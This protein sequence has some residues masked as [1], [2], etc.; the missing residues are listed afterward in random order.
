MYFRLKLSAMK[1]IYVPAIIVLACAGLIV[2]LLLEY[3]YTDHPGKLLYAPYTLAFLSLLSTLTIVNIY[4]LGRVAVKNLRYSGKVYISQEWFTKMK[5]N[6]DEAIIFTD[7]MGSVTSMN[8]K[9]EQLTGWTLAESLGTPMDAIFN[10]IND[11]TELPV[12]SPVTVVLKENR[13]APLAYHT[14]VVKKDNSKRYIFDSAIPIHDTHAEIIGSVLIFHDV[15]ELT[16]CKKKLEENEQLLNGIIENTGV[17]IDARDLERKFLLANRQFKNVMNTGDVEL[18]RRKFSNGVNGEHTKSHTTDAQTV[19]QNRLIEHKRLVHHPD[20]TVHNYQTPKFPL[21]NGKE[22]VRAICTI[23]VDLSDDAR[24]IEM[25]ERLTQQQYIGSKK[26]QHDELVRMVPNIFFSLDRSSRFTGV[27]EAYEKFTRKTADQILGKKLEE[28]FPEIESLFLTAYY[29]AIHTGADQDFVMDFVYEEIASVFQVYIY[30]TAKGIS[31]LL[32]DLSA[33]KKIEAEARAFL[34]KLQT[35][36]RE[37]EQF[38]YSFSHDLRAPIARILEVVSISEIDPSFKLNNK[39]TLETVRELVL[40]LD[41][42]IRDMNAAVT[43][44][45]ERREH[46]IGFEDELILIKKVLANDITSNKAVISSSFQNAEGIVTIK[47]Y[48]YSIM[49][50]LLSNAIKY[51]RPDVPLIIDVQTQVV[52]GFILFSV[53]DNGMGIDL[54]K[55][56]KELFGLYNRFHGDK[57]DGQGIGLNLVKSQAESL[58][59]KVEVQSSLGKGSIFTIFFPVRPKSVPSC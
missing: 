42:V 37:L 55:N 36:N 40:D 4:I 51:R 41:N 3:L 12:D 45:D 14:I 33:K 25:N 34:E 59:G 20:G 10:T 11:Q 29:D 1:K 39:T 13:I 18:N 15:T 9:A 16:V 35:K 30:Q 8:K 21:Y 38:A 6:I 56:G 31:V 48:L 47:S 5:L 23:S 27:N 44:Q 50:N 2:P 43:L 53:R 26:M 19:K 7:R 52:D 28:A 22:Y 57:I 24:N 54:A 46:Y 49:Y 58:G 32:H 17:L